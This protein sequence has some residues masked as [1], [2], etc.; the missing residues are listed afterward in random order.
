M[1]ARI[2]GPTDHVVVIAADSHELLAA[3]AASATARKS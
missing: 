2:K 1:V 3:L